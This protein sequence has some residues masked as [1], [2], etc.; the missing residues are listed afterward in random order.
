[1]RNRFY[2]CMQKAFNETGSLVDVI[3]SDTISKS[4]FLAV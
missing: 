3:A 2:D 4:D 1:V